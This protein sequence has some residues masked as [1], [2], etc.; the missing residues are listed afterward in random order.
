MINSFQSTE[1]GAVGNQECLIEFGIE[2][3]NMSKQDFNVSIENESLLVL[4]E[5]IRIGLILFYLKELIYLKKRGEIHLQINFRHVEI[6]SSEDI[7]QVLADNPTHPSS[8]LLKS[9]IFRV[10]AEIVEEAY[11]SRLI[12][13]KE[14]SISNDEVSYIKNW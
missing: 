2:V 6:F 13:E 4:D 3:L 7:R 11:G 9:L 5:M 10:K 12:W 8:I 1:V 14:R